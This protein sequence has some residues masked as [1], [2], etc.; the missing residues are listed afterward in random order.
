MAKREFRFGQTARTEPKRKLPEPSAPIFEFSVDASI[1][2][3]GRLFKNCFLRKTVKIK[4]PCTLA[5]LASEVANASFCA[6]EELA[7][8][9][10]IEF[11]DAKPLSDSRLVKTNLFE[12]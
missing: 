6:C 9:A 12:K 5:D 1:E 2:K 10:G 3:N 8:K 7:F 11:L 4:L